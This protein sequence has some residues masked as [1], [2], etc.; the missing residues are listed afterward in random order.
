[1]PTERETIRKWMR[2][3]PERAALL[4]HLYDKGL[5]HDMEE[6]IATSE[7]LTM[8][9]GPESGGI[10]GSK[11]AKCECGAV[12]WLSPSSQE[13]L[14][15]RGAAPTRLA[16]MSCGGKAIENDVEAGTN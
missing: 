1:M 7:P 5:L 4:K 9:C 13:L 8:I 15:R 14:A 16:C 12:I 2:E 10:H 6:A 3:N 11:M